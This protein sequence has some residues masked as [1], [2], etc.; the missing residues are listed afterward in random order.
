MKIKFKADKL[1][2]TN[3]A[4]AALEA[5]KEAS[6]KVL[7]DVSPSV[8]Y[9]FHVGDSHKPIIEPTFGAHRSHVGATF[10]LTEGYD[11][12]IYLLEHWIHWWFSLCVSTTSE[13][14]NGVEDHLRSHQKG[15]R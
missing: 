12:K 10:A 5:E 1:V 15:R 6:D 13:L 14:Q 3:I 7:V 8:V 4:Q 9:P 11:L 2:K